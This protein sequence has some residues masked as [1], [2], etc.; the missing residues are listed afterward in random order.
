MKGTTDLKCWFCEKN[1]SEQAHDIRIDFE[2]RNN[3]DRKTQKL[4]V[5]P[6]MIKKT[7]VIGR[8][9]ACYACH[10][11]YNFI[12]MFAIIPMAILAL[13]LFILFKDLNQ[14]VVFATMAVSV[15]GFGAVVY[16]RRRFLH[17]RGVKAM[18]ELE[19]RNEEIQQMLADGW[20]RN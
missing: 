12:S 18:V 17:K 5:P 20:N 19:M 7:L 13:S 15:A 9:D 8:C 11:M 2:R 6:D 4:G 14:I 1:E 10:Q 16:A 3:T